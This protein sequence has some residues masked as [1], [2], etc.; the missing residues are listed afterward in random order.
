MKSIIYKS[1]FAFFILFISL[2]CSASIEKSHADSVYVLTTEDE[3]F[4]DTLQYKTFKFFIDEVNRENGLVPDRTQ[5]WSASSIAAVGWG[6]VAWGIGAE[7]NWITRDEAVDLTL[8]LVWVLI[9]SGL[10]LS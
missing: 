8:A 10:G 5:D 6:V 4:L 1:I 9:N 2:G 3:S 7:R